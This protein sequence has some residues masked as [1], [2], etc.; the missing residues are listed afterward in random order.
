MSEHLAAN[1]MIQILR[2][3]CYCHSKNIVHRDLKPEN[4]LLL[5]KANVNTGFPQLKLIDFGTSTIKQGPGKTLKRRCGTAYYI[6]P[7][8]LW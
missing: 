4:I 3:L 1:I 7:E 6:A 5:D 2:A 8:V